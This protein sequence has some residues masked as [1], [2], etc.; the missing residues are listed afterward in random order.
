MS[1]ETL[2]YDVF[3][4]R[5]FFTILF[6]MFTFFQGV[7]YLKK[8]NFT[9]VTLCLVLHLEAISFINYFQCGLKS[10]KKRSKQIKKL[11]TTQINNFR[12]NIF[13]N[14]LLLKYASI[15]F[16]YTIKIIYLGHFIEFN[17]LMD[18]GSFTLTL[19]RLIWLGTYLKI[20]SSHD[21][22]INR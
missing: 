9:K 10:K 21:L 15:F 22:E 3:S 11:I 1:F 5:C 19:L 14:W 17:K 2:K 7:I 16:Y 20:N 18:Q 4:I 8:N 13:N 6:F 12:H